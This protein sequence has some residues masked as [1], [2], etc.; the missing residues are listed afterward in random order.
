MSLFKLKSFSALVVFAV[1]VFAVF[2]LVGCDPSVQRPFES[3]PRHEPKLVMGRDYWTYLSAWYYTSP[4]FLQ[5]TPDLFWKKSP[6]A[7]PAL[8]NTPVFRDCGVVRFARNIPPDPKGKSAAW[9]TVRENCTP[10][11]WR[12]LELAEKKD[13]PFVLVFR[14]KRDV[15]AL[16]GEVDVD[17]GDWSA[18]KAANPNMVCTRTICEWGNDMLVFRRWT[19]RVLNTKRRAELEARYA[20]CDMA[21]RFDRLELARWYV[22]RM[23]KLHYDDMDTFMA[24]RSWMSLD[25]IAAAW[26]AK[27]LTLE[28]TNTTSGDSEY[29][30][31]VAG[32][33]VRGAARQ[34][35]LPWAWYEASY[36]NGPGK[37]GKWINNSV[38]IEVP[39]PGKAA[40]PE[41]G[42]SASAQRRIWY[43]A[44]LNGANGVESESW[45]RQFFTTNT[46]SGKAGL[47]VRGRNFSDFHDFTAAHPDRGV[48]YTPVAILTPFAQGYTACGGLAWNACPYTPGDYAIDALFFTI[49]PGWEREKGLKAGVQEGNLHNSRFAMMYDVLVPDSPQPKEE[50]AKALFAYPAAILVD[51]YP[52]A[53]KFEDVLAAYEKAGGRLIRLTADVLSPLKENTLGEIKAGRLKFPAVEQ[54][55]DGLQRDLF[56]FAVTGDCQY[57]ANRTKDGWWLWAFNNKGVRKFADTF[58]TIDHSK[59]AEVMVEFVHTSPAPVKE[60][61]SDANVNVTGRSFTY[62]VPAGDFAVFAIGR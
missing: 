19:D 11:D 38:C 33:L 23:L 15:N 9:R 10:P 2:L 60:L 17:K 55:L 8:T 25:H 40:K 21:N 47:S 50:F 31:D 51:D 1:A 6:W 26:G 22:D 56:P 41:A 43:Y 35:G 62:T 39:N 52:D 61:I 59:D 36:F 42:T 14:S 57:G 27:K 54:I 3:S 32:M 58:E 4:G 18:F 16:E 12:C 53:S 7:N 30:W 46:P 49:A 48:T 29:R 34:F 45:I 28:T 13:R 44:Y 5:E 24:F 37:D 20:R